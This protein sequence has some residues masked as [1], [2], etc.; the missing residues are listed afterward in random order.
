MVIEGDDRRSA[1]NSRSSPTGFAGHMDILSAYANRLFP[2][3]VRYLRQRVGSHLLILL[4]V[5]AAVACSVCTQYGMKYL[6]DALAA[7]PAH[8]GSVWL[9]FI[10]LI[11]LIASDVLLWRVGGLTANFTFFGV[12]RDLLRDSVLPLIRHTPGYFS[13]FGPGSLLNPATANSY[14]A[15]Y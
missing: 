4:A 7:G 3:L 5:V 12:P 2:F 14:A 1:D 9:A 8:S 15:Y 11:S 13:D 10:F 6:V